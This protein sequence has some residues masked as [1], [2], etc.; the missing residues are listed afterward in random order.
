MAHGTAGHGDGVTQVSIASYPTMTM[1]GDVATGR[2]CPD[3][4]LAD[5]P[6]R[7]A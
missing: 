2:L 6:Q 7:P 5:S 1:G 3:A 4:A